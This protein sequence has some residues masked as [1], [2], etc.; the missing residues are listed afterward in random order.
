VAAVTDAH[1]KA[2]RPYLVGDQPS[3]RERPDEDPPIQREWDMHCPV[4]EDN[5]RSAQLN[6][7]KGVWF[8]QKCEDGGTV[9]SLI[10]RK[11]E[12]VAPPRGNRRSKPSM[13]GKGQPVESVDDAKIVGWT[14]ALLSHEI[15]LDN[16]ITE[17]GIHSKTI[18]KFEIGWDK[19]LDAYTIPVRGFD[20]EVLNVRRYQIHPSEGR[21]KIWGVQGMNEPRLYPV[22]ILDWARDVGYVIICEGELDALITIQ[23]GFPAITRTGSAKVWHAEWNSH[24]KN[25]IIFLCHDADEAG[26]DGNRKVGTALSKPAR[27]IRV[28]QLPYP[29]V[30]KHGKDLT[31]W[32]HEHDGDTDAFQRMLDDA[33]RFDSES[34]VELEELDPTDANVL[35]ALD[36][37]KVGHPLRLTVTIKGKREPGYS[38]PRK[39]RYRCTRDAG[40]RCKICPLY[41][42][43][44]DSTKVIPGGDPVVLELLDSTK[45]QVSNSIREFAEIVKC[46]KLTMEVLEHQAVEV[47]F[48]RPSVDHMN[49][50][51]QNESDY[52]NV[53]LTSVGRHDTA[54]NNTVSVVGAL[55]P[56]PRRQLNEFL[57][58]DVTKK[59]TSL[60]RFDMDADAI[61]SL[62]RFRPS[63]RQTPLQKLRE[64]ADEI[65]SHVT[66]IYGRPHL[67]AMLDLTFHSA[68]SF[69]FSGKLMHRGWLD[70]L[71]IG[72]TRT[73][74]S[75]TATRM[76][77][78]YRA[79]E[80]ISCEAASFAGIVGGV[81]QFG[82]NKEWATT[83]G[84]IP[85]NDRRLVILDE[86]A[87]LDSEEIAAMSSVRSSGIAEITK[88]RQERT[89]ART[90]LIWISNP[91]NGRMSDYTY[92]VQAIQ[93]LVGNPEDIARFD[94]ALSVQANE[95]PAEE[96]NR[97]HDAGVRR[98]DP[99]AAALL[100]RWAWSRT[101]DQ[102][103]WT[104]AAER[105]VYY[106][107]TQMGKRYVEDPPLVQAANVREKIA[108]VAVALAIRLFSTDKSYE[109]VVVRREHVEGAVRFLDQ[110]YN[111]PNFGY[112]ER[113]REIIETRKHAKKHRKKIKRYLADKPGLARFLR[114][115]GKFRR[116]DLEEVMNV[117]REF[118][119]GIINTL[120]ESGM[121]RK[122]K[123]DV[124]VEPTLH[125]LLRE[126]R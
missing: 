76:S 27:A 122:I 98:F 14:S 68:L 28:V 100:V 66:F 52:K 37:R 50:A 112:A 58:W 78:F 86:A 95:V 43:G 90:R 75:E 87:G 42:E 48:A 26:Q 16:L 2:L 96:I 62:K 105:L 88:I 11:D 57:V 77:N 125:D 35:D 39:I 118:A 103:L 56:D 22:S 23:N 115:Q 74:K 47:L 69:K 101:A 106:H 44:G 82:S 7:D 81:Q 53:K 72:D 18:K 94:M 13:N 79:G 71:V 45:N 124:W 108:R 63:A 60:D 6:L 10:Q 93:P 54:S 29:I 61:K 46:P 25:L 34:T 119:N 36:S 32:W 24:F 55:H 31:D 30:E 85:I 5:K 121:V 15:A 19:R 117:D 102:I 104:K 38:I 64:I 111:L 70:V 80:V 89:F 40:A 12:W 84:A 109:R 99:D 92:G 67:H 4:H 3:E 1:L 97:R 59:E 113:S 8:C 116:Q 83:W 126:V 51:E 41:G 21:R 20:G 49:G 33:P 114:S 107:A 120:W 73:G 91:R 65:A 17:R 123:G 9:R 110:I